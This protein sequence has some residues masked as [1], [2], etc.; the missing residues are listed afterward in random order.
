MPNYVYRCTNCENRYETRE[1][2]DAPATQT[3]PRCGR[4]AQR[5]LFAP[6]I[7]FK[8]SGFYVTDSKKNGASS[9]TPSDSASASNGSDG[10]DSAPAAASTDAE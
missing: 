8:G 9:W 1:G 4:T 5:V 7:L 3:C 2:F 6:S 10:S